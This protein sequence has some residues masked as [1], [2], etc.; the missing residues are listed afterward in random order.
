MARHGSAGRVLLLGAGDGLVL[1]EILRWPTV[2]TVDL[3]ELDPAV[4]ALARR[5]PLVQQLHQ[6]SLDDPRLTVHHGDASVDRDS[7]GPF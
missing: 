2:Q 3:I 5:H 4:L 7:E 6:G 1:R